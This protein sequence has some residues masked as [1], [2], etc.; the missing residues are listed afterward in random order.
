LTNALNIIYLINTVRID[1]EKYYPIISQVSFYILMFFGVVGLLLIWLYINSK[2]YKSIV[3][4]IKRKRG[5]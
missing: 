5:R 1:W 2:R 3:E 4:T